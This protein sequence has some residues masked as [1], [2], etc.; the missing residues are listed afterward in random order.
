MTY[1]LKT[2]NKTNAAQCELA[3]LWGLRAVIEIDIVAA[4]LLVSCSI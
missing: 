1:L 2:Q 4:M 3:N